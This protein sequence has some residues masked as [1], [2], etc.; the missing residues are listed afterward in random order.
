MRACVRAHGCQR[1]AVV[2]V[3]QQDTGIAL[4]IRD[5]LIHAPG[6][7]VGVVTYCFLPQMGRKM[8]PLSEL[9]LEYY[10]GFLMECRDFVLTV[11][12]KDG[13]LP[14]MVSKGREFLLFDDVEHICKRVCRSTMAAARQVSFFGNTL[15]R[16]RVYKV[17]PLCVC[18]RVS[19]ALSC[20]CCT[21]R[22]SVLVF[23]LKLHYCAKFGLLLA[24]RA[25]TIDQSKWTLWMWNMCGMVFSRN[26][27][28]NLMYVCACCMS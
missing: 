27:R 19:C 17:W 15:T 5:Q 1:G 23:F 22:F 20:L 4:F 2:R 18:R 10:L 12:S 16:I 24:N 11:A 25:Y 21:D 13:S 9:M 28:N 3:V 8:E 7:H 6:S 26:T 14:E